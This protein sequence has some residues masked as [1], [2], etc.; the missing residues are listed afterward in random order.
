MS[1]SNTA[2]PGRRSTF[3]LYCSTDYEYVLSK[4][5]LWQRTG[6]SSKGVYLRCKLEEYYIGNIVIVGACI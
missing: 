2:P 5:I 6:C 4:C 1:C 3:Y